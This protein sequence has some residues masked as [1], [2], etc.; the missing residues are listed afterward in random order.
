MFKRRLIA[1]DQASV[2]MAMMSVHISSGLVLHQMTSDHNRSELGIQDH[3][4]EP[5]SSKLVNQNCSSS[6]QDNYITTRVGITIP[7]SY[8]NAEDNRSVIN[9]LTSGEIVSLN[10]IESIKKHRPV[11]R[12]SLRG[13]YD[14]DVQATNIVLQGLPPDVYTLVNHC[15]SAK[16]IWE[17]IKLLMKDTE[18]SYQECECKIYNEFDKFTSVKGETLHE[19]YLRFAQLINDMHTTGITMQQVQLSSTL[20]TN[21]SSQPYSLTYEAPH[22][23]QQYQHAYQPQISQPT[24]LVPKNAYHSPLFS[25]QPPVEF[26]QIDSGLVLLVFLPGD[27]PIAC[28]NKA[29]AFMSTVVA[30]R[31][32][33]TNNQLRTSSNL[34]NQATIQDGKVTVQHVQGR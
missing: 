22:H 20:Q 9:E 27:D 29:M 2:F 30:S 24:P 25:Q 34:R 5:S 18:L 26:P 3:N 6:S 23:P 10:F 7:P 11:S 33:S 19:Y 17:R 28:L 4:N 31:F 21:H 1:A 12:P 13:D 15:Q 32:P 14:C 8:S 16:D